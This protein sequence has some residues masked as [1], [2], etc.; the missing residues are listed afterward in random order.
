MFNLALFRDRLARSLSSGRSNRRPSRF[1]RCRL[2]LELLEDRRLLSVTASS[3]GIAPSAN[4]QYLLEL[5]N[6]GRADPSAEAARY[7]IGLNAGLP[8]GTIST[9]PKQPLAF[10][11]L[12][13]TAARGHSQW[14]IDTNNFSHT[15]QG[16]SNAGARIQA[17]GYQFVGAWGWAENISW[18]G[19]TAPASTINYIE[20]L[21][22]RHADLYS[23]PGHRVNQMH[24]SYREVGLGV[25][26]GRFT[27]GS[28]TYNALMITENFAVSGTSVFLTG[29]V[30]DD[31]R[32]KADRFYTP[33]EGLGGVTIAA[34]SHADGQRITAKTWASGGYSLP[35][36]AGTY[37]VTASG[38]PLDVTLVKNSVTI[39]QQNVKI[40]FTLAD[41]AAPIVTGL[42]ASPASVAQSEALSLTAQGVS[43][44]NGHVVEVRF[45]R[46]ING[47]GRWDPGDQLLGV[48]QHASGGWNWS[49]TTDGWPVGP[50]TVFARARD[51]QGAWSEAVS[52]EV[53]VIDP[54]PIITRLSAS[55]DTVLRPGEITLIADIESASQASV[56]RVDF[57]RDG[58]LL[59]TDNQGNDG[60]SWTGNT[61][62]WTLG[63]HV[64]SARAWNHHE[65]ASQWMTTN[66]WVVA[67]FAPIDFG[68][69]PLFST[70]QIERMLTNDGPQV[71]I[72]DPAV[73]DPP[74][75]IRPVDGAGQAEFWTIEPG[76]SR[77]FIVSYSPPAQGPH[78]A[79][80]PL[81][82]DEFGRTIQYLGQAADGWQ[83]P[84]NPFDVDGNGF[85]TA[86]DVLVLINAINCCDA[87]A[88]AP[89]T[90]ENPGAPFFLDPSGD[91]KI[92]PS[93]VL[94]V[95]NK[96]NRSSS[97]EPE[98]EA[99]LANRVVRA[100]WE[101]PMA[102]S[103][104][105]T[106]E[107]PRDNLTGPPQQSR[108]AATTTDPMPF[109][110]V[111]PN[112][113]VQERAADE[114]F[115]A[116]LTD[117]PLS[118]CRIGSDAIELEL[119]LKSAENDARSPW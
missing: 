8:S 81:I 28:T 58:F 35:L 83:N 119:L 64:F 73:L 55:P 108:R 104:Q 101:P 75:A 63:Q 25:V 68:V 87:R 14:M 70:R 52:T 18:K 1:R 6:R 116:M 99:D 103:I 118:G 34:V 45:Y 110:E 9:T 37:T 33:G 71:L 82:G 100:I 50:H 115:L 107:R 93:D 38:G 106:I 27:S 43:D 96:I 48:D 21:N 60:W 20:Y 31:G 3:A 78:E 89:R 39:G 98:G 46:D 95:I 40:D 10:S 32:V 53:M 114:A 19:T 105:Q 2:S 69:V 41:N 15:G 88:L 59:G 22:D 56:V 42:T 76:S 61:E 80:L 13:N 102:R 66:A 23:R 77:S 79:V 65:V 86:Q 72:V 85:V 97:G 24:D 62:N 36:P 51:N 17:A 117:D 84:N 57:Y 16:G 49:G 94:I 74:Y 90:A 29:V 111:E 12:L 113:S 109:P 67:D 54:P 11:P 112:R 91:G 30:Y 47:D 4:E 5:I 7:N 44:P 26:Q 92:T